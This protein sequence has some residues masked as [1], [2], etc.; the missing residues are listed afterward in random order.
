MSRA[1]NFDNPIVRLL[2]ANGFLDYNPFTQKPVAKR[3]SYILDFYQETLADS[4]TLGD[5][6]EQIDSKKDG[7]YQS[8]FSD[9]K[10]KDSFCFEVDASESSYTLRLLVQSDEWIEELE[11]IAV[12]IYEEDEPEDE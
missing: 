9:D 11:E 7:Y 8:F 2:L 1:N 3:Y 12:D 6:V 4:L 10:Y 5:Y